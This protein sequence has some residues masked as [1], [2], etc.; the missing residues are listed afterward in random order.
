MFFASAVVVVEFDRLVDDLGEGEAEEAGVAAGPAVDF[1]DGLEV[2]DDGIFL[3]FE[4]LV[5][6]EEVFLLMQILCFTFVALCHEVDVVLESFGL[7]LLL[8]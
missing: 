5:D 7:H 6:V 2:V 3:V 4:D 8:L 1:V